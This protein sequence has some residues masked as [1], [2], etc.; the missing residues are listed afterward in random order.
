MGESG[1]GTTK[2]KDTEEAYIEDLLE[3]ANLFVSYLK[4][5]RWNLRHR[6]KPPAINYRGETPLEVARRVF[7]FM[8]TTLTKL[9]AIRN[10]AK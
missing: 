4:D 2:V 1:G 9:E 7:D 10:N 5:L 3:D 8:V 6:D